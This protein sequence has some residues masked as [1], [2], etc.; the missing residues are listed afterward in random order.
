MNTSAII[1]A[2]C[3]MSLLWGGFAVCLRIAMKDK[4]K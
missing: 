1:V 3:S 4:N 2:V